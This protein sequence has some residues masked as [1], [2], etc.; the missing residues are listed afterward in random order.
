MSSSSSKG[1][2]RLQPAS[3]TSNDCHDHDNIVDADISV[4]VVV[5]GEGNNPS[6][7]TENDR[8]VDPST[9]MVNGDASNNGGDGDR[10]DD[11]RVKLE[12]LA[13]AN[14][15]LQ[16][17]N[18]ISNDKRDDDGD[19]I[20]AGPEGG[21]HAVAGN[22]DRRNLIDS[23]DML[24]KR[25]RPLLAAT[26]NDDI[27]SLDIQSQKH[28]VKSLSSHDKAIFEKYGTSA[29]NST[30]MVDDTEQIGT[31]MEESAHATV[32]PSLT[33]LERGS[34]RV[35]RP[36]AVAIH[37]GRNNRGRSMNRNEINNV[38][39][40]SHSSFDN[41]AADSILG[42]RGGGGPTTGDVGRTTMHSRR[43]TTASSFE[44]ESRRVPPPTPELT[45]FV[46]SAQVVLDDDDNEIDEEQQLQEQAEEEVIR[47]TKVS[48]KRTKSLI[49]F[50]AAVF[51]IVAIAVIVVSLVVGDKSPVSIDGDTTAVTPT[52][53][54][55]PIDYEAL[56]EAAVST[57]D[58]TRW[59]VTDTIF[60]KENPSAALGYRVELNNDGNVLALSTLGGNPTNPGG[61][62]VYQRNGDDSE[63]DWEQMG[64]FIPKFNS[65]S[66]AVWTS[67][68]GNGTIIAMGS[69]LVSREIYDFP[70][71]VNSMVRVFKYYDDEN[72]P[73]NGSASVGGS[74]IQLGQNITN[75]VLF[76]GYTTR[77]ALS[78]DG[79][80][81]ALGPVCDLSYLERDDSPGNQTS[82]VEIYRYDQE[83]EAWILKGNKLYGPPYSYDEWYGDA[84][85]LSS[86]GSRVAIASPEYSVEQPSEFGDYNVSIYIGQ[87]QVFE[88]NQDDTVPQN[89]SATGATQYNSDGGVWKQI[90]QTIYGRGHHDRYGKAMDMSGDGTILAI[91]GS[92]H[93]T[94][95]FY[96]NIGHV[97]VYRL[98][99]VEQDE[100][101]V[102]DLHD[103]NNI[104]TTGDS[105]VSGDQQYAYRWVQMG[106]ED[107]YG[108]G[109][110]HGLGQ[111]VSLSRD[112]KRLGVGAVGVDP[113]DNNVEIPDTFGYAKIFEFVPY[114]NNYETGV[115]GKWIQVG[116]DQNLNKLNIRDDVP[117]SFG[118]AISLSK[119]GSIA[120]VSS[121]FGRNKT[122]FDNGEE[123]YG[124]YVNVYHEFQK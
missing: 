41:L 108:D 111:G 98:I 14:V 46:T 27:H 92:L 114:D 86:D 22:N 79:M 61:L 78:E 13:A 42:D 54:P 48:N 88:Y 47:A 107:I 37:F 94:P 49:G 122:A 24:I 124:G 50:I 67:I 23:S 80:T 97:Q 103:A 4:D 93:D 106:D 25:L 38:D 62:Y 17:D 59:R 35:T 45:T 104:T 96:E 82:Y 75:Q 8:G 68:N 70:Y 5:D 90:G 102:V 84:I 29:A 89:T 73:D 118:Y 71:A 26:A 11:T 12:Q 44:E 30:P 20:S 43:N 60:G 63:E 76:N 9:G 99:R 113:S 100:E 1:C 31:V 2:N 36:G 123:G 55:T 101:D 87:I 16:A 52:M 6:S 33:R 110:Y 32:L 15:V 85:V 69:S 39:E 21:D 121:P 40:Y 112:G 7:G 95:P 18:I 56:F 91:G 65:N 77:V 64:Q 120:A 57:L 3:N 109:P 116:K 105:I 34:H 117:L 74:W 19:A 53:S 28:E 115:N 66:S 51:G 83:E 10:D 119:D 81:L 58:N 72:S